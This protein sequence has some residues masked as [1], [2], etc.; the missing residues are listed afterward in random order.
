MLR[1][2]TTG[3]YT[4]KYILNI[5]YIYIP[6]LK[7]KLIIYNAKLIKANKLNKKLNFYHNAKEATK[8]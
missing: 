5:D 2:V 6:F 8:L 7:N 3:L 1:I 4:V